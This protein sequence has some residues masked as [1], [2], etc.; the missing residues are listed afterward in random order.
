MYAFTSIGVT[1][2]IST[3]IIIVAMFRRTRN[4]ISSHANIGVSTS[5]FVVTISSI[6][7]VYAITRISIARIIG[8]NVVIVATFHRTRGT[9]TVVANI[10][11]GTGVI[12]IARKLVIF[13][14]TLSS[15][16]IASIIGTHVVIVAVLGCSRNTISITTYIIRG[17]FVVITARI[18][19]IVV[20]AN[21]SSGIASIVGTDIL[22]VAAKKN[23]RSTSSVAA[24]II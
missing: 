15:V 2:I 10:S 8:T 16:G 21:T 19:V 20:F 22:V 12:I 3:W 4:A 6:V 17:T 13:M 18:I 1:S 23:S 9:C 11:L 14:S 7:G 5:I 24:S